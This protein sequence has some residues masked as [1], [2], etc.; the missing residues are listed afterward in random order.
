MSRQLA[1]DLASLKIDRAPRPPRRWPGY[2]VAVALLG[3]A[4]WAG[5][6]FGKPYVEARVFKTEVAVTEIASVSPAQATVDL[7]A[8]GYVVPQATAKV[9]TKIVGRIVKV[10]VAEGQTVKAGDILF[11]LDPDD[12]KAAVQSA[13][14]RATAAAAKIATVKAQVAET[15]IELKRQR[16]LLEAGAVA[17]ATVDDLSLRMKSQEAAVRAAEAEVVAA[18]AEVSS[19]STGMKN[20]KIVAPISGT[21]LTKPANVGDV[22][23]PGEPLVEL[24]DFGSLLAEVDVPEARLGIVKPS[25]PCEVVL[26]ALPSERFKGEVVDLA[27][28][29]NRAKAT[30][31]VKVK[32][33][34]PPPA[35]RP[36]MSVRVSFLQKALDD[37]VLKQAPKVVVPAA[38]V[39]E[40]SGGKAVWVVQDGKVRLT[41]VTIGDAFGTGFV[42]ESGPAPGTRVVKDPPADLFDGQAVKEKSPS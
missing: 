42:V 25:G 30:G 7:T 5:F 28:K 22:V 38:A 24:A 16:R 36:E 20:L 18:Q 35:L 26:D 40:K 34:T 17:Q 23:S 37:A 4:G 27:P 21:A 31:V 2:V 12:Q 14:A 13:Q 15:E 9:G 32:L 1:A 39:I 41:P 29:L 10:A 19:L 33:L 11:E 6:R 3:G 8:T